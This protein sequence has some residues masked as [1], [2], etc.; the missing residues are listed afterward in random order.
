MACLF[1]LKVDDRNGG[2]GEL[3]AGKER[4]P[5]GTCEDLGSMSRLRQETVTLFPVV[6]EETR[7][8]K[9]R[10]QRPASGPLSRHGVEH[11]RNQSAHYRVED[12]VL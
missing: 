4:M 8:C 5:W 12:Q 3:K 7:E 11:A 2:P 6:G 1:V 9:K 10:Q